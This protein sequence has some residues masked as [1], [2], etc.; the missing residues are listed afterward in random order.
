MYTEPA[1]V[2]HFEHDPS[3]HFLSHSYR[4]HNQLQP[5]V[6]TAGYEYVNYEDTNSSSSYVARVALGIKSS[7]SRKLEGSADGADGMLCAKES[8]KVKE[9]VREFV[10]FAMISEVSQIDPEYRSKLSFRFCVGKLLI[11]FF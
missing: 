11:V 9:R 10:A 7:Q 1:E 4:V 6:K 3:M 5:G 8:V 2:R